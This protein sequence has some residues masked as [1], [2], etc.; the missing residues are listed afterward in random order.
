MGLCVQYQGDVPTQLV[1]EFKSICEQ[2][3]RCI[4]E[5]WDECGNFATDGWNSRGWDG[6]LYAVKW[7]AS[8]HNVTTELRCYYYDGV[9]YVTTYTCQGDECV[10][11]T[12]ED[13]C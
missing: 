13:S 5:E 10:E 2:E 4:P 3:L 9:D 7:I 11:T 1:E 12:E 6:L 8:T